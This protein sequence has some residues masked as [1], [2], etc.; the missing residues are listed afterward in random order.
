[1]TTVTIT[2]PNDITTVTIAAASGITNMT[3]LHHH[4]TITANDSLPHLCLFGPTD[5]VGN[6]DQ[7]ITRANDSLPGPVIPIRK[8]G[9]N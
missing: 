6:L 9:C 7:Q 3:S 8:V 2:A 1:M 4:M 5:I